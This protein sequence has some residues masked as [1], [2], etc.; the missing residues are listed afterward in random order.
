MN[1]LESALTKIPCQDLTRDEW[2]QVGMALKHEGYDVSVWDSWSRLDAARYHEGECEKTW[3]SFKG[4]PNPVTGATICKMARDRGWNPYSGKD[5]AMDWNDVIEYDGEGYE[6]GEGDEEPEGSSTEELMK[7]ISVLFRPDE[8]VRYCVDAFKGEDGKWRPGS[9]GSFHRTARQLI[10]SLKKYPDDLGATVGDWEPEAGAWIQFNASD[11]Q[12]AKNTNVVSFRYALVESDSMSVEDQITMYRK[13]E[14]PVAA[15]VSSAGKSVHAIVRVDAD[16][17]Q[18][19]YKRVNK[20]YDVLEAHG[21]KVDKQN[22]NPSRLSRMPGV[23]RHGVRQRLLG[24]NI[25]RRSWVDWEDYVEGTTDQMPEIRP[26]T[27]WLEHPEPLP[28]ELI[29]GILRRGHKMLVSGSSKAGK[30]FLLMELAISISEGRSWLGFRCRKGRVLYINL[31]IDPASCMNRIAMIYKALEIEEP[32][33]DD[34]MV[35]NLRGKA[36]PLDQLVPKLIRR[37]RDMHLDAIIIDPIYKVIMGDENNAS[38]MAAFCNEFDKICMET[39]CA[40]IYCHHHSKGD[41]GMKKAIDRASGSGVFARDPDAQLDMIQLVLDD[42]TKD[43]MPVEGATAWRLE[44][45]LR[46]FKNI[47]PVNFWFEYPVHRL[48]HTNALKN[49][50]TKAGSAGKTSD[51]TA[52]A[53]RNAFYMQQENGCVRIGDMCDYLNISEKTVY[54]RLKTL[55]SEF[56]ARKGR[57]YRKGEMEDEDLSQEEA[58]RRAYSHCQENGSAGAADMCKTLDIAES[59]LSSRIRK[60]SDEFVIRQGRVYPS[61]A[62]PEKSEDRLRKVFDEHSKNGSVS[63]AELCKALDIAESTLYSWVRKRSDEFV[64]RRGRVYMSSEAGNMTT[65]DELRKAFEEHQQNGSVSVTE[66]SRAMGVAESTVYAW[67]ARFNDEFVLKRGNVYLA[68]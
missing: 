39:G 45:A 67:L 11:G 46:E 34:L 20:L 26:M 13:L 6:T 10:E 62:W 9:S 24:T 2:L 58:L 56:T 51:Q 12:G 64:L 27:E 25:G 14:L 30:S 28:E 66:L 59:T 48:D 36:V 32:H 63:I 61:D 19:Y 52:E 17:V 55:S 42:E 44:S 53:F 16:N 33:S 50:T 43:V 41:Q 5:G 60:M 47:E 35:W 21:L 40:V 57:I 15:L 68:K 38:D 65:E 7:Y 3:R 31:E 4:S 8:Y 22:R 49:M 54:R 1:N 37:V 18:E 29:E 23:T